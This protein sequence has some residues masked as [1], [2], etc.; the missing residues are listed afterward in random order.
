MT[1]HSALLSRFSLARAETERQAA[2]GGQAPLYPT[3]MEVHVL[4]QTTPLRTHRMPRSAVTRHK[5]ISSLDPLST[6]S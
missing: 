5:C 1:L 4:A 3:R 2:A 6:Q